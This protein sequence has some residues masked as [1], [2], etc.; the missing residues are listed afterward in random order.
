PE[1]TMVA[2]ELGASP[3]LFV[4]YLIEGRDADKKAA[5]IA[6]LNKAASESLNMSAQDTRVIIQDVPKTDMGVAGGISALAAGR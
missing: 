4:A 6:A 3:L 5:L 2:G 1:F